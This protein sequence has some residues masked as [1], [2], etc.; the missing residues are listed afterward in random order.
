MNDCSNDNTLEETTI[1]EDMEYTT[2]A[3]NGKKIKMSNDAIDKFMELYHDT[4]KAVVNAE[5]KINEIEE[6]IEVVKKTEEENKQKIKKI[7][8]EYNDSKDEIILLLSGKQIKNEY[9]KENCENK[10]TKNKNKKHKNVFNFN[11]ILPNNKRYLLV[12]AVVVL[13]V[14]FIISKYILVLNIV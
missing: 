4:K 14:S 11:N 5:R 6:K 13:I 2:V 8:K 10:N 9:N 1:F 12:V 7:M 3:K